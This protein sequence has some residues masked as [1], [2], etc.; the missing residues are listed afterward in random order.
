M[1]F[2]AD[3]RVLVTAGAGFLESF[4]VEELRPQGCC[5][6]VVP[7]RKEYNLVEMEAVRR[8]YADVNSLC[9]SSSRDHDE[10]A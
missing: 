1:S 7:R 5:E 10:G 2:G 6:I 9:V 3:K 4:V 8:L